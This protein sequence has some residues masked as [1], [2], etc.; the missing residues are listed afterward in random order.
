MRIAVWISGTINTAANRTFVRCSPSGVAA[1]AGSDNSK[2]TR[3]PATPVNCVAV[4]RRLS[5]GGFAAVTD[6]FLPVCVDAARML[7]DRNSLDTG[8]S[9]GR[10]I[11]AEAGCAIKAIVTSMSGQIT[12]HCS[13]S[14]STV[15]SHT[16]VFMTVNCDPEGLIRHNRLRDLHWGFCR[17]SRCL[18]SSESCCCTHR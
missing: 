18:G 15:F 13:C 16:I 3:I 8:G 11:S 4:W 12:P 17:R 2:G 7:Q 14:M 5:A 6:F 9:A 10:A 1:K